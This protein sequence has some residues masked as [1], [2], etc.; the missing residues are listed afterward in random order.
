MTIN[1]N[2]VRNDNRRELKKDLMRLASSGNPSAIDGCQK[3]LLRGVCKE[4]GSKDWVISARNCVAARAMVAKQLLA[5][6]L[7]QVEFKSK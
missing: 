5:K 3:C 7:P 4:C 1:L 6:Y 2:D